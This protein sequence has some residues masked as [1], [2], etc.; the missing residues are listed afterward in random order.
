MALCR[1][2]PLLRC[3]LRRWARLHTVDDHS[4]TL[5]SGPSPSC[6]V[7]GGSDQ[8][9]CKLP[10]GNW[11][12]NYAGQRADY[13]S[14]YQWKLLLIFRRCW[15]TTHFYPSVCFLPYSGCLPTKKFPRLKTKPLMR[16]QL[17]LKFRTSRSMY[18]DKLTPSSLSKLICF[19]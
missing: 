1:L 19:S 6:H 3:L 11:F 17:Y 9:V 12:P 5:L 18:C 15:R 7:G 14:N 4:G 8:L 2:H 16:S 13:Q 10:G